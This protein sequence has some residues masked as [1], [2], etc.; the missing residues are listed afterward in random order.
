MTV[1]VHVRSSLLCCLVL[2][3]GC[4]PATSIEPPLGWVQIDAGT[5]QFHVPPDVKAT[6]VE[7]IDSFVGAYRGDV[8]AVGFDYGMYSDPLDYQSLPGY[9]LRHER[10]DGK[11]A[12]I[13]SYYSPSTENSF[14]HAIAIHFPT[15]SGDHQL[16]VH[17]TCRT[18]NDCKTALTLFRTIEFK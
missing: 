17:A 9:R 14:D 13:V 2:A 15:V 5:F 8:I 11:R 6:P 18:A 10:I 4:T 1:N 12:N 3:A 16:T 7:G